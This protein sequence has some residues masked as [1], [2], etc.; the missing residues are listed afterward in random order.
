M[1]CGVSPH[2]RGRA[3]LAPSLPITAPTNKQGERVP[4]FPLQQI[5]E[6]LL[7]PLWEGAPPAGG[8]GESFTQARRFRAKARLSPSGPSGHLPPRGRF[9]DTQKQGERVPAFPLQI[10]FVVLI[11]LCVPHGLDGFLQIKALI[12][13]GVNRHQV[14]KAGQ[15]QAAQDHRKAA[16]RPEQRHRCPVNALP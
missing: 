15:P 10:L 4:A 5:V 11:Q 13:R 7:G 3:C 2:R 9:F 8:G 14:Q 1:V 6:K 12:Q 16:D